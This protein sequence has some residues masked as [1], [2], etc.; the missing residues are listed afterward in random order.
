M[1]RKL[2]LA[3]LSAACLPFAVA[4]LWKWLGYHGATLQKVD[5]TLYV[6][7][8]QAGLQAGWHHLYDLDAQRRLWQQFPG[9]WWFPNVYT[10]ALS[11]F[12]VPFAFLPIE[13]GYWLFSALLFASFLVAWWLMAPGDGA[14]RLAQ[15]PIVLVAYPL[16]LGLLLGQIIALQMG[17]LA[18]AYFALLRG[19]EKTAGALLAV[20]ALKPQG[21]MLVPFALLA[22]GRW[23]L[24]VTWAACMAGLGAGTLALIGA[25]G[26]LAYVERLLYAQAHLPEFWVAWSY[27]LAR[28]LPGPQLRAAELA[29]VAVTLLAA[30][31]HRDRLELPIA[32]GLV[33]SLV[34]SPFI[35]LDDYMLLVPA[36][37]LVLRA[38]P[39][40]LT[41]GAMLLGWAAMVASWNERAGGRWL[42]IFTCLFLPALAALPPRVALAP[43]PARLASD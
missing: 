7:S 41:S 20:I 43:A 26:A 40:L 33:G 10:P 31:R 15:L 13:A 12:M 5:Y 32:A 17:A 34:A 4:V 6:A 11:V 8:A 30:W 39:G 16:A 19:R 38:V 28:R 27:S 37:W 23:R 3:L 14:A 22:A 1:V 25:D 18:L 2:P 21:L 9:V 42:L 24:F 29:A 36:G 35:H